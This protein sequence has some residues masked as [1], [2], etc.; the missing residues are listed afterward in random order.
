MNINQNKI[1]KF[2]DFAMTVS[3]FMVIIFIG[4]GCGILSLAITALL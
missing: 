3:Y 2:V 4:A 1:V